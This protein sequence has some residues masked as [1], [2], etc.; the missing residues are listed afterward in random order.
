[1]SHM[2]N[3]FGTRSRHHLA[4]EDFDVNAVNPATEDTTV[5]M[6][7]PL[8]DVYSEAL[9]KVF[10]KNAPAEGETP[11]A[12]VEGET[13]P[14]AEDEAEV[15]TTNLKPAEGETQE[16]VEAAI[17]SE[18]GNI[19]LESQA[20]DSVVASSLA[21]SI[22][23]TAPTDDSAFETLYAIDETQVT[24]D[25]VKDVTEIL[26]TS[27]NP[28]NVT[29]LIDDVVPDQVLDSESPTVITNSPELVVAMES[30]V[31]ALGGK[32]VRNF[33]DYVKARAA[34]QAK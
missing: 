13:P 25:T 4:M 29:V 16:T 31:I 9:G 22:S 3:L 12:P 20:I 15:D 14:P 1:M 28:E 8:A 24:P 6:K 2:R 18:V 27:E 21:D 34:R 7:G 33:G 17:I 19:V 32:V 5:V 26:A 11:P 10:D 23:D 30:M